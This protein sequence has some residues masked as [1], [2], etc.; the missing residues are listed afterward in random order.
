MKTEQMSSENLTHLCSTLVFKARLEWLDFFVNC[1]F[2]LFRHHS[3][4]HF[5][6]SAWTHSSMR[7]WRPIFLT[8]REPMMFRFV[9]L[10]LFRAQPVGSPIKKRSLQTMRPQ[11]AS[12][13]PKHILSEISI[14]HLIQISVV[15]EMI[16]SNSLQISYNTSQLPSS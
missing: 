8:S 2:C 13:L 9:R 3:H 12:Q 5:Y 15:R 11:R 14:S 1:F 7:A 10:H 6:S 4:Q 16:K